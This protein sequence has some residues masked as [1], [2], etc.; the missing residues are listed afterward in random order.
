VGELADPAIGGGKSDYRNA[1][2]T[3][4]W[5]RWFDLRDLPEQVEADFLF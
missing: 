3:I 4:I 2:V 1:G 5:G